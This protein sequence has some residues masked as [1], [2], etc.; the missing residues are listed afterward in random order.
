MTINLYLVAPFI[1]T[2]SKRLRKSFQHFLPK[3]NINWDFQLFWS[4][5]KPK[6]KNNFFGPKPAVQSPFIGK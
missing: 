3:G 2:E 1:R 4:A 5:Y 6:T